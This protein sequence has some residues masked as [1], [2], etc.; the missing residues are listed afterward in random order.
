MQ[1]LMI[2]YMTNEKFSL[3][4]SKQKIDQEARIKELEKE[5]GIEEGHL[6]SGDVAKVKEYLVSLVY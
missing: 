5:F 1:H 4:S 6:S 2:R 3:L